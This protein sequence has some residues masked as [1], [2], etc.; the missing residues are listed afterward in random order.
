MDRFIVCQNP[1]GHQHQTSLKSNM[2]RFIDIVGS[3]FDTIEK[4]KIQYG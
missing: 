2:D 1:N 4:F 3:D